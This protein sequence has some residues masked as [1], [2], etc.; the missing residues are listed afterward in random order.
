M[1]LFFDTETS[2]LPQDGGQL[3][4]LGAILTDGDLRELDVFDTL[5]QVPVQT[6][7]HPKAFEAHGLTVAR[8]N[9]EGRAAPAALARFSEM[10]A[11][12]RA[13]LAYNNKFDLAIMD[14]MYKM[15]G[16]PNP[17]PALPQRCLMTEMT[18]R[19]RIPGKFKGTFK[20]PKLQEAHMFCTGRAFDGAHDALADVRASI[21]VFRWLLAHPARP[22]QEQVMQDA[23]RMGAA[24]IAQLTL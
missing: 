19:A 12:A 10:A 23:L 21:E 16:L 22:T 20:W 9:A 11:R 15:H 7:V 17:L 1:Y 14:A 24:A 18:P 4:Q 8:V 6:A 5:V 2:G 13:A 3:M